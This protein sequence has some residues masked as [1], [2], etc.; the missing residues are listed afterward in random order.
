MG[1]LV[2]YYR[3]SAGIVGIIEGFA[4]ITCLLI[5]W[6]G[7]SSYWVFCYFIS[8]SYALANPF[9][10]NCF[11]YVS[12]GDCYNIGSS[13]IFTKGDDNPRLDSV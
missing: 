1:L 12:I 5:I 4:G 8:F 10:D 7:A 6:K 3:E 11:L 9:P 2:V 13:F